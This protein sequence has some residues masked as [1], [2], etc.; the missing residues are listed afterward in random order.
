MFCIWLSVGLIWFVWQCSCRMCRLSWCS[1]IVSMIRLCLNWCVVM[2]R[3][4]G[5]SWSGSVCSI[6]WC[7]RKWYVCSSRVW[8]LFRLLNRLRLRLSVCVSWWLCKVVWLMWLS[9]RWC[10]WFRWCVFCVCRCRMGICYCWLLS[11][12]RRV[13]FELDVCQYGSWCVSGWYWVISCFGRFLCYVFIVLGMLVFVFVGL[14]W[15]EQCWLFMW[16]QCCVDY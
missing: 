11:C 1:L 7:R 4:L 2:L 12:G 3:W 8:R 6:S 14:G 15:L 5:W 16:Y 10:W 9:V 13:N